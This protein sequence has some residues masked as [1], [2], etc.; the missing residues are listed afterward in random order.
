MAQAKECSI[1]LNV[2][3]V[4]RDAA[5]VQSVP[6]GL[7]QP[8][9]KINRRIAVLSKD[10]LEIKGLLTFHDIVRSFAPFGSQ[11]FARQGAITF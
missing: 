10:T 2:S 7:I 8:L 9:Y 11:G 5:A 1:D 6:I 4:V 3:F